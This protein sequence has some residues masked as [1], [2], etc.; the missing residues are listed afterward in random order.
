MKKE[1]AR[2][3]QFRGHLKTGNEITHQIVS[4][5]EYELHDPTTL[6]V[7][8]L[9][10]GDENERMAAIRYLRR[11]PYNHLW[12]FSDEA[13][14][15]SVEVRGIHRL[16]LDKSR[17]SIGATA[18]QVG[19]TAE[20]QARDT[21]W[22]LK[23]E[24]TPSGIL[25]VPGVQELSDTGDVIFEPLVK[26]AIEVSTGLGTLQVGSRY[27]HYE[28]EEYGDKIIHTVQRA[29]IT[30]S[31]DIPKGE[32]LFSINNALREEV[33]NICTLLSL[34]YRQPVDYYEIKY[35]ESRETTTEKER[36]KALL[37]RRLNSQEK[38]NREEELIDYEN[39]IDG[40][41]NRL[42]QAYNSSTHKEELSRAI[43]FLA[44]SYKMNPLESSYFL[45]YSALDLLAS[46]G[47][48]DNIYLLG[49]SK[50]KKV[51]KLLREYL[52]SLAK[53]QGIAAVVDQIKGK[54][55]ELRRA[56]GDHR[57]TEAC[58]AL[59][60]NTSDLWPGEG[61][62]DGLKLATR[63]RNE[64]FHSALLE[65]PQELSKHLVRV[66]ILVERLL[67]KI[68]EWPDE[69]I[70]IWYDE[71]LKWLNHREAKV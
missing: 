8:L 19:I 37:R 52:D 13:S 48:A 22:H 17:A 21:T 70:W 64:L 68:L 14:G 3:L 4:T 34:C 9:P 43:R 15:P 28:S 57:I 59:S 16:S 12:L 55:P 25:D 58:R 63:I 69:K 49:A 41:L 26:G 62:E 38:K 45:A 24:L 30:G 35:S 60:V 32:D 11:L 27:D 7:D 5:I 36:R 65:S 1:T 39:L 42:L 53:A 31:I 20:P 44:A 67:L 46:T 47:K 51:E 33:K 66:R 23:A 56:S 10:L 61:F 71:N 2:R 54:L 18:V 6:K 40:G 29:S 50:W